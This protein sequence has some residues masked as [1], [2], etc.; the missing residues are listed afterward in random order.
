MNPL[1][2]QRIVRVCTIAMLL[3]WLPL[4]TLDTLRYVEAASIALNKLEAR[5]R[6]YHACLSVRLPASSPSLFQRLT[7]INTE[8][9][10]FSAQLSS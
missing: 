4:Q 9:P 6:R 8:K 7:T 2:M 3:T 5:N 1:L 10:R